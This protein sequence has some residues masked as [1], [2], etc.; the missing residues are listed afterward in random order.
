MDVGGCAS[1]QARFFLIKLD[2]DEEEEE[3]LGQ[4]RV[5]RGIPPNGPAKVLIRVYVV[6]ASN[7]H[8]ADADG[9]SDPYIVLRLGRKEIKDRENYIPKQLNPVFGRSFEFQAVFPQDSVLSVLIYDY[10]MVGGDDLIGETRIDLENRLYSRHRATCGLPSEYSLAGYNAW[11]DSLKPSELL[12]KLCR[13]SHL[14]EP[15]FRPGRIT[16]G[17]KVFTGKTV[18]MDE[19]VPVESYEHLSLKILHRWGEMPSGCRLVPEHIETR[20]LFNKDRPG[21]DQGQVQMW[22]DMYPAD[23][24]HPGPSVD[25]SP[26]KPKGSGR[27]RPGGRKLTSGR[28]AIPTIEHQGLAVLQLNVEGLTTAKLDI[29]RHLADSHPPSGDALWKSRLSQPGWQRHGSRSGSQQ[30]RHA[31]TITSRIL[32]VALREK[33]Y[34]AGNGPS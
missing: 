31:Y 16:V 14:E 26:R 11:R 25:I 22:V 9:K 18:F 5:N 19:D 24:P 34:L 20:T 17:D 21:L 15:L 13:D 10:D 12:A 4:L 3:D 32:E 28:A 7:L 33:I 30:D 8:P 23:L 1:L 27:K 29:I 2:Q 6:S